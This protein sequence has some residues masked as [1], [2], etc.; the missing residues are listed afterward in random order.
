MGFACGFS[1][2]LLWLTIKGMKIRGQNKSKFVKGLTYL[3][4]P[5]FGYY[6]GFTIVALG[7]PM[8]GAV[9]VGGNTEVTYTVTKFEKRRN[10]SCSNPITLERLPFVHNE[11]CNFS[12]EFGGKFK[13]SDKIVVVGKGT[14]LG[15]FPKSARRFD[16]E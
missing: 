11:L 12:A 3:F 7:L 15:V 1:V 4:A 2:L 13:A 9:I 8:L 16:T 6:I 5:F 14:K 10:R